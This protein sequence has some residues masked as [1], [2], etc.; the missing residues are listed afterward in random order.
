MSGPGARV[1]L[2]HILFVSDNFVPETNAA[3]N[4]VY[5][6]AA[7]W[8]K[9]GHRV[10]V[11]T[12]H[13]NKPEGKVY[14]GYSNSWYRREDVNGIEVI[15]VKTFITK[16]EGFILRMIDFLSFMV[17]SF[18]VGLTLPRADVLCA[19]SPQFFTAVSGWLLAKLKRIPFVFEVSDL[20]PGSISAVGI[21]PM[22]AFLVLAEYMEL[23]LY[24]QARRVVALTKSFKEDM[25]AR[26]VDMAKIDVIQNGVDTDRLEVLPRDAALALR[27]GLKDKFVVGYLGTHGL[28][29][30]LP[31]IIDLIAQSRI[32]SQ[33]SLHFL[34]VGH[35]A[36]RAETLERARALKLTN[37][38]F[39]EGQAKTEVPKLW[40]LIDLALVSLKDD[41]VFK[42][43]IPSKIFEAMGA[44]KPILLVCP[45][46]EAHQIVID[47]GA[48]WSVEPH[49]SE[50]FADAILS[51]LQDKTVYWHHQSKSTASA[52]NFSRENQARLFINSL[53]LC[54]A[55]PSDPSHLRDIE[56]RPV[57]KAR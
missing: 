37:V 34:F 42:L 23:F 52:A 27:Y 31:H 39:V 22:R 6:R 17:M 47:S 45:Q 11:L 7:Y 8:V 19:T 21:V 5:E 9:W 33:K 41:P 35:G 46:G 3:A 26:G 25:V 18:L 40:S 36:E 28:A 51:A 55:N 10:T 44:G 48:G 15:R 13:P 56:W 14:Q 30:G 4:R 38:T 32:T 43:F 53:N 29:Q 2:V 16:N 1:D 20:W 50:K 12:S 54:V 57:K 24:A 49:Q